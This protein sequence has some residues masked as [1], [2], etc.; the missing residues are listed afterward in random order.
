MNKENKPT[1]TEK[2]PYEKPRVRVIDLAADEVL[3]IG[4]KTISGGFNT[5]AA[6]CTANSCSV[7]GS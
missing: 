2:R 5:G 1:E 3:A 4:C 6:P 7:V